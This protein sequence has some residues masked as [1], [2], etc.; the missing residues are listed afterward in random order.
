[1]I[2][3]RLWGAWGVLVFFLILALLAPFYFICL[4]F[5][6]KKFDGF[7]IWLSHNVFASLFFALTFIRL[8]VEG[9]EL[10][11]KEGSYVIISNHFGGV[12]FM[13]NALASPVPYKYLVKKEIR[14]IPLA[15]FIISRFSVMVDRAS[16]EARK[17]SMIELKQ[18]LQNGFSIFL[19]PEGTR[20]RTSELLAPFKTGAFRL[21]IETGTPIAIQTLVNIKTITSTASVFNLWPGTLKVVL[22][23]PIL[24]NHLDENDMEALIETCRAE[25]IKQLQVSASLDLI[26]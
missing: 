5:F 11:S 9:K 16:K 1:M 21:A 17:A 3:R 22:S 14:K 26:Q 18:T 19:Y 7:A 25:M 12:D 8:H 23:E 10:L 15:G 6:P 13:A 2:F 24:T 20:N 4:L